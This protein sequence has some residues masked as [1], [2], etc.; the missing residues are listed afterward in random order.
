MDGYQKILTETLKL[1]VPKPKDEEK[2]KTLSKRTLE[3]ANG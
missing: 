2:L 1:V 3:I